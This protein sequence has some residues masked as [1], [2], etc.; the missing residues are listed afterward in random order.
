MTKRCHID[1]QWISNKK[2]QEIIKNWWRNDKSHALHRWCGKL[3]TFDFSSLSCH[4]GDT[5]TR[6]CHIDKLLINNEYPIERNGKWIR[7]ERRNDQLFTISSF[8]V[9]VSPSFIYQRTR[10]QR[11]VEHNRLCIVGKAQV[12][13]FLLQF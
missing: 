4:V 9:I 12:I 13:S 10:K 11:E 3:F 6:R 7:Y 8:F 5:M 2:K 1:K